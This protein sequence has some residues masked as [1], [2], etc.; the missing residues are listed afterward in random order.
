MLQAA[1]YSTAWSSSTT[2]GLGRLEDRI[3]WIA[4]ENF[5]GIRDDGIM[6]LHGFGVRA[7]PDTDNLR[8]LLINHRPP[9][10]PVTGEAL[11]A[12][13]V[14]VNSTIELF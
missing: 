7:D 1:A 4:A 14:G 6:N 10:N 5:P 9:F 3:K 13:A 2:R 8:I 11:D 12:K